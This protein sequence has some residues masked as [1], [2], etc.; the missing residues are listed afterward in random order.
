MVTR[1]VEKHVE[2]T[3]PRSEMRCGFLIARSGRMAKLVCPAES[4]IPR[5]S[6]KKTILV[7]F[8]TL[9]LVLNAQQLQSFSHVLKECDLQIFADDTAL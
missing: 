5:L 2:D 9:T 4:V 3:L 1:S 7:V 6:V 8:C